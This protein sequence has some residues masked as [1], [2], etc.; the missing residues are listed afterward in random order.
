[1][2]QTGNPTLDAIHDAY[3]GLPLPAKLALDQAHAAVTPS[4]P[5]V[6]P[7]SGPTAATPPNPAMIPM[8][9]ATAASP[10]KIPMPTVAGP[11]TALAATGTARPANPQLI[12]MPKP[13]PEMQNARNEVSRLTIPVPGADRQHNEANTGIEKIRSPFAR[14]PLQIL[15]A[16]GS[17]LFPAIAMGI[18]GTSA[19]HRLLV[20]S[21]MR[22]ENQQEAQANEDAKRAQEAEQ[23]ANLASEIPLHEAEAAKAQAE[24]NP[25]DQLEWAESPEPAI[26][27]E[28]PELGPQHFFYNK[29]N[30]TQ[31]QFGGSMA[32]KPTEAKPQIHALPGVGLVS[33][34]TDPKTGEPKTQLVYKGEV[35]PNFHYYQKEIG[36]KPHTMERNPETGE[37][38]DLGET[39]EKPPTVNV[40][41]GNTALDHEINQYGKPWQTMSTGVN[42]QLDKI[43]DAEK[44]VAGG[45]MQQ[46]L[47]IPKVLTAL[48]SGQGSGVRITQ[49]ELNMIMK[50]RGIQGDIEGWFKKIK[51]EGQLTDVQQQQL[52]NILGDV[53]DRIL[54]KKAIADGAINEM[55]AGGSRQDILAADKKAR[56][57]LDEFERGGNNPQPQTVHY[58]AG[59]KDYDIPPDKEAAFLKAHPEAK[60]GGQ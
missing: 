6:I 10:A 51:G 21:A 2:A 22:A 54:Q 55:Q 4:A 40:N 33:V 29:A 7:M 48:V 50:A 30:P 8:P 11:N 34:T 47:G 35:K 1:M 45:A 60:K 31:R 28:H 44:M 25:K 57:A 49:P 46:A 26:D 38:K 53:R 56:K 20:N 16:V 23:T 58:Q 59:G 52:Q 24:A 14:I 15:D 19:H 13:A 37:E 36:G 41:A 12:Q 43:L 3:D 42:G 18:P 17:G 5:G 39:G 9:T 32:A 27:P